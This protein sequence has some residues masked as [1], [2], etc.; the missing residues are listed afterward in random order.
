[1][2]RDTR[3]TVIME[4]VMRRTTL[5]IDEDVLATLRAEAD[6]RGSSLAVIREAFQDKAVAVRAARRPRVGYRR[7]TDGASAARIT[8]EQGPTR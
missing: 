7:S 4:N 5:A 3:G 1:M 8:A 2:R 6:R